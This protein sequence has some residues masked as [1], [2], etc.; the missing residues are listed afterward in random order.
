MSRFTE[1]EIATLCALTNYHI[2]SLGQLLRQSDLTERGRAQHE[3]YM[4]EGE[5]IIA[6]LHAEARQI[7]APRLV[8]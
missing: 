1:D 5:A 3:R 6:K 4:R 2:K 8:S 7:A